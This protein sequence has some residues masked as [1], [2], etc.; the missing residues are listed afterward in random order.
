MCSHSFA[1]L[2]DAAQMFV[3]VDY[4]WEMAM[5]KSLKCGEY[6]YC[7]HLLF[8]LM[9]GLTDSFGGWLVGWLV[10]SFVGCE[11]IA[12]RLMDQCSP[13]SLHTVHTRA[14][15]YRSTP[16][17]NAYTPHTRVYYVECTSNHL[18][19]KSVRTQQQGLYV[20]HVHRA[21][22]MNPAAVTTFT[23]CLR[24]MQTSRA[25]SIKGVLESRMI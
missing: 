19:F 2:Y 5:E 13:T 15:T 18:R 14:H 4:V 25:A 8:L 22:T 21:L 24:I 16:A 7:E 9:D 1:K 17:L 23:C 20:V 12:G 10:R 11:R 3:V 6:R